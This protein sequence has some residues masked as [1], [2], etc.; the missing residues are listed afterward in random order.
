M[1]WDKKT[2]LIYLL[3]IIIGMLMFLIS[4]CNSKSVVGDIYKNG[5]PKTP[6]AAG[7]KTLI[8]TSCEGC[9]L[10]PKAISSFEKPKV[11]SSGGETEGG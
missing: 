2:F 1:V 3:L 10:D 7:I 9:H 8:S 5:I 11:E 6:E 4:G